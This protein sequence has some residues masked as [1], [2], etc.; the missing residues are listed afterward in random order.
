MESNALKMAGELPEP[1]RSYA[2]K[3]LQK[4]FTYIEKSNSPQH[5]KILCLE[6]LDSLTK[7]E[8]EKLV[9]ECYQYEIYLWTATNTKTTKTKQL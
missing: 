9:K 3:K 6:P 4:L 2:Q 7:E 8:F 5:F 1:F